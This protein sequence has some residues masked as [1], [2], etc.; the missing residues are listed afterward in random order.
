MKI[1]YLAPHAFYVERGTPISVDYMMQSL[2]DLGHDV[3]LCVYRE[4]ET[5]RYDRV[6]IHRAGYPKRLGSIGPGFSVKKLIA[7]VWLIKKAWSVHRRTKPDIIH[8]GEEMVFIAM[9][10]KR[11]FGTPYV[12]DMDSS[13]A[14]QLVE[15]KAYLRPLSRFFKW[16]EAR[17]IRGAEAC[18]PVCNALGDLA[19]EAG[20]KRVV[21]LHDISQLADPDRA[22]TGSLR[23]QLDIPEGRP[24][25][26][27]VGN[28]EPY[29]GVELLLRGYAQAVERGVDADLVIVG[30]SDDDIA[31]YRA[32]VI[33]R[34][35]TGRV[36]VIGRWPAD[37]LD[38]ILAEADILTA[39]RTQGINTPQ[40]IFPYMHSGRPVLLTDL[41]THNQVVDSSICML[42]DPTPEAFAEAIAKLAETPE[43]RARLGAAGRAFVEADFTYEAHCRRMT[44][45]YDGLTLASASS[46]SESA[47]PPLN[48]PAPASPDGA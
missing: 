16:C 6:T 25:L 18:A 20:A 30:G 23:K 31:D 7:D 13:L 32:R 11:L 24:I 5:R 46:A 22:A 44:E 39:P 29:Q 36:H 47:P 14:Q 17:A 4:G 1:Q 45:L 19:Q 2:S 15:K 40:K 48:P 33:A 43:L 35:L 21:V 26:M 38:E 12:Y 9:L 27:Y 34:E 28:L 8:A 3:E 10:F 37:Q 42:A 41:T